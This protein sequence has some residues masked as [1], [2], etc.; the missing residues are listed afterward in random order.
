MDIINRFSNNKS[1]HTH[2]Q[3]LVVYLKI[4]PNWHQS[5]KKKSYHKKNETIG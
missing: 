2:T 4:I 3:K 1:A 5:I